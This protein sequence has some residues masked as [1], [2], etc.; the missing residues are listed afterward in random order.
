M[1]ARLLHAD[2]MHHGLG[3]YLDML[4]EYEFTF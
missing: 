1:F 3:S 2:Y 4:G